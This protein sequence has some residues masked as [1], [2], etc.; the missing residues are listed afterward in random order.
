MA[1]T[2]IRQGPSPLGGRSIG[3][4]ALGILLKNYR[5]SLVFSVAEDFEKLFLPA[6]W[7]GALGILEDS[8]AARRTRF[9]IED[10]EDVAR[11]HIPP[12]FGGMPVEKHTPLGGQVLRLRTA[13]HQARV[14]QK[15]VK[16]HGDEG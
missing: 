13:F 1:L 7:D 2:V 4:M 6:L 14:L 10:R 11:F 12:G 9:A 5:G 15:K 3:R 8:K 16:A